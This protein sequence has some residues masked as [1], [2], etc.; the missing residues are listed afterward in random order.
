M[1]VSLIESS[2]IDS[3]NA[4]SNGHGNDGRVGISFHNGRYNAP[5]F[6]LAEL[7]RPAA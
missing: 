5:L 1:A 3:H 7:C 4:D 6:Q 2:F